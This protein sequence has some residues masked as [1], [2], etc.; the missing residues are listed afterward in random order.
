MYHP[1]PCLNA[2][3]KYIMWGKP[4]DET[5]CRYII[6]AACGSLNHVLM[7]SHVVQTHGHFF[8]LLTG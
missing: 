3:T 4:G 6:Y 1:C 2:T 7:I 5:T 8:D